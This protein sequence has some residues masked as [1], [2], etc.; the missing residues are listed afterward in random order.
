MWRR[1]AATGDITMSQQRMGV[2]ADR[3]L[4]VGACDVYGLPGEVDVLEEQADAL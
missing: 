1:E 3:A 2:G 4:A